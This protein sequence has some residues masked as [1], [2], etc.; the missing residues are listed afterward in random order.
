MNCTP[1]MVFDLYKQDFPRAFVIKP[2]QALNGAVDAVFLH[3][4][5]TRHAFKSLC[6][7]A[8][9]R[10]PSKV[11]IAT[12]SCGIFQLGQAED[13]AAMDCELRVPHSLPA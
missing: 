11:T 9:I 12:V 6:E 13:R 7:E 2:M 3:E 1:H 4:P 8:G 5:Q 10:T